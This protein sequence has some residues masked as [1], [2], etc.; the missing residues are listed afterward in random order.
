MQ[1]P[2]GWIHVCVL[3]SRKLKQRFNHL[4]KYW[5]QYRGPRLFLEA[6]LT[7]SYWYILS[8]INACAPHEPG[9]IT[10]LLADWCWIGLRMLDFYGDGNC[11]DSTPASDSSLYHIS[12]IWDVWNG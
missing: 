10:I 7:R 1:S 5:L 6:K 9:V 12:W 4:F 8:Q 11:D 3:Y 2:P